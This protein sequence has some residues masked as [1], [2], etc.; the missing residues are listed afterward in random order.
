VRSR[1][2]AGA[3][4]VQCTHRTSTEQVSR[5]WAGAKQMHSSYRASGASAVWVWNTCS[6]GIE[7]AQSRYRAGAEHAQVQS[8]RRAAAEQTRS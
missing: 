8:K 6:V 3:E 5:G 1:Y 2:R 4:Q 7:Q